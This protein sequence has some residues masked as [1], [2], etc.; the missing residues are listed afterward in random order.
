MIR[1]TLTALLIQIVTV[2]TP[3]TVQAFNLEIISTSQF[4]SSLEDDVVPPRIVP[5]PRSNNDDDVV[6]PRVTP[7]SPSNNDDDDVVPPRY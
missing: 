2:A 5:L 6:P 1:L 7:Q 3:Q 4:S